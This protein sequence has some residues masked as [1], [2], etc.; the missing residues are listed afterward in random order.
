MPSCISCNCF[1]T[2]IA[3][4][5]PNL[6]KATGSGYATLETRHVVQSGRLGNV[7]LVVTRIGDKMGISGDTAA[8]LD[9]I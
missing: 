9:I 3:V 6:K 5:F 4:K 7:R 2:I 8:Y 1:N